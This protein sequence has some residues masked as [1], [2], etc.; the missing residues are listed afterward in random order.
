MKE[1]IEGFARRLGACFAMDN[2]Y[3]IIKSKN[4]LFLV[5]NCFKN[6][7]VQGGFFYAGAYLGKVKNNVFFPSFILLSMIAAG[8][9]N[10]IV[11]NS[12]TAWLFVCGRDVFKRGVLNVEGLGRKGDYVLILNERNE[13]LGFGRLQ[14]NV[15]EETGSSEVVVKNISDIGD[16]LRREKNLL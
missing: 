14:C 16:F 9:A 2:N 7:I 6:Q 4:R 11:V 13:C 8:K 12:R 1:L 10:K 15:T 3:S 5:N